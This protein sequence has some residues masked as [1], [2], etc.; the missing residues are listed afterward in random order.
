M[1]EQSQSDSQSKRA[2]KVLLDESTLEEMYNLVDAAVI[3]DSVFVF[4]SRVRD[5][6]TGT[7]IKPQTSVLAR[8]LKSELQDK[9]LAQI[10]N[11]VVYAYGSDIEELLKCVHYIRNDEKSNGYIKEKGEVYS[12]VA[13]RG[14]GT[15]IEDGV[16]VKFPFLLHGIK[17]T[18]LLNL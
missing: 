7:W 15:K 3:E 9:I 8:M 12:H 13:L 1:S 16:E 17:C 10:D 4:K 2:P 14:E 11:Q 18:L 5:K 6:A